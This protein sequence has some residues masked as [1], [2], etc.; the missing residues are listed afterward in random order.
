MAIG[1]RPRAP[2]RR[3][4]SAKPIIRH[5]QMSDSIGL[6]AKLGLAVENRRHGSAA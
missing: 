5:F 4:V 2:G 3:I 1:G 6:L